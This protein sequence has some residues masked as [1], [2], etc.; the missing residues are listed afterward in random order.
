VFS[1]PWYGTDDGYIVKNGDG[2]YYLMEKEAFDTSTVKHPYGEEPIAAN[3]PVLQTQ[4]FGK[5][6]CG[7]QGG[8]TFVDAIRPDV[9]GNCP[10]KT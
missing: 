7:K 8:A 5:Y 1:S 3:A 6:V 9:S 4:F 2:T 10:S